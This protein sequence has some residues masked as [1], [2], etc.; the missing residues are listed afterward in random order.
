[1]YQDN[2]DLKPPP[3]GDVL[4]KYVDFTKFVS[5]LER[6]ALFFAN[7]ERFADPYEGYDPSEILRASDR[8]G[9]ERLADVLRDMLRDMLQE[10]RQHVL[11]DCW[12]RNEFESAA[13]WR[14]YSEWDRGIAIKTTVADLKASLICTEDISVGSVEYIDY[15]EPWDQRSVLA[16][17]LTK[18]VSF[19]HE[20]EVRAISV[21]DDPTPDGAYREVNVE[22]L[23]GEVV[24]APQSEPWFVELVQSVMARYGS[25]AP[26][27]RSTLA[28]P[29]P[30]A[31]A[32]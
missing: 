3:D 20:R 19:E 13:M 1:M 14:L 32:P 30:W 4:W 16:P 29:P 8:I 12:H 25:A 31:S 5:L 6:E 27:R 24:V 2:P 17:Y 10:L 9:A 15:E 21:A 11:V 28:D 18:R 7:T 22:R 26:V 23:I